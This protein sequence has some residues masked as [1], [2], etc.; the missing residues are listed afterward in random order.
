MRQVQFLTATCA[1]LALVAGA[2]TTARAATFSDNFNDGVIDTSKWQVMDDIPQGGAD[3]NE[4]G[5]EGVLIKRG[6]LV[7]TAQ[8]DPSVTGAVTITGQWE[9]TTT[10]DADMI[11]VL[12]RSDGLPAGGYGE[13]NLGLEFFYITNGTSL[14]I[15]NRGSGFTIAN[16]VKT[17]SLSISQGDVVDFT[18]TDTGGVGVSFTVTEV[19]N[20]SNTASVTAD[21]TDSYAG[22]NRIVFHNREGSTRIASLDDVSITSASMPFR[23]TSLLGMDS[24]GFT[25]RDVQSTGTINNLATADALLGGSGVASQ[26]TA[27]GVDVINY[28]NSAGGGGNGRYGDDREFPNGTGNRNDFAISVM[29]TLNVIQPGTY[30]FGH[31]TDDGGRL[32]INGADV[33]VNDVLAGPHDAFGT[34]TLTAGQHALDY[35]YFERGGGAEV[36]LFVAQGAHTSYNGNFQLLTFAIPEPATM[37]AL[38]LTVAGLGGYVKRRRKLA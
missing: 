23:L 31:N 9:F 6:H 37:V 14:D 5:G 21:V 22:P 29:G 20:P 27:T 25:V 15:K 3:V 17:G 32:R 18:I 16:E 28:I 38:G 26:T 1:V 35:V 11:Q 7:T 34:V 8:W 2:A 4:V 13:T 33:F 30:T 12:T 24:A 19:G 36:E 10:G